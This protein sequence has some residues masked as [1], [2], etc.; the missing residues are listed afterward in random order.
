MVLAHAGLADRR[1]WKHQVQALRERHRVICYDWRGY[2]E[3]GDAAGEVARHEDLLALMDALAVDQAA[4]I[5]CS[6]GGAHALD[7]ALAAPERVTALGLICSAL[8]GHEWPRQMAALMAERVGAAVP[9]DRLQGYRSRQA[10]VVDPAD[11]AAMAEANVRLL[12][13]GP[14]R[15]P[16]ELDPD[17]WELALDMC[18]GVFAGDWTGPLVTERQLQPPACG[19]LP[20]VRVPALVI[21]GRADVRGIQ[22]V[23]GLLADGIPGARRVDPPTGHLPPLERPAA[24]SDALAQLLAAA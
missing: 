22:E 5:G 12:V 2:G 7:A 10:A 18:R 9:A 11:V 13:A 1:M 14:D 16:V 19:R 3:S 17:V 6:Y 8:S 20:E 24:V 21:N 23:S 15:D 4:L